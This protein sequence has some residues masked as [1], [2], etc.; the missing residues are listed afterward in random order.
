MK[1][2]MKEILIRFSSDLLKRVF[3]I[4]CVKKNFVGKKEYRFQCTLLQIVSHGGIVSDTFFK[5][6]VYH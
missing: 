6:I 1:E 3:A 5:H 4:F 2:I